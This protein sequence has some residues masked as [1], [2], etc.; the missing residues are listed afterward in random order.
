M[1]VD[2]IGQHETGW[3]GKR[4][5]AAK[6]GLSGPTVV[7]AVRR[8]EAA[9]L[10]TVQRRGRGRSNHYQSGKETLPVDNDKRSKNFTPGGKETLPEAVKK[11]DPNQTDL[12]NQ[13]HNV[14]SSFAFVM[15]DGQDYNLP[16]AKLNEYRAAYPLLDLENELLKAA[17]WLVDNPSRRKTTKGMPRFLGGWLGRAE[18]PKDKPR[19]FTQAE[20]SVIF[21]RY[22]EEN[23]PTEEEAES[24]LREDER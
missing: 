3:P 9:G 13:T 20:E 2:H 16:L 10:L 22:I 23:A 24:L 7:G 1:I 5:I 6:A 21:D 17:Q 8:L 18:P 11:L 15:N 12:L 4:T 14:N 19:P